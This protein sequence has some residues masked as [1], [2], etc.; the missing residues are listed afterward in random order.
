MQ[1]LEGVHRYQDNWRLYITNNAVNP[2]SKL[3]LRFYGNN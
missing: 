2:R 3:Q 1:L